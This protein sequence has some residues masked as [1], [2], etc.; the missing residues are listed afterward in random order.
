MTSSFAWPHSGHVR[1]DSRTTC[2]I[3]CIN[4]LSWARTWA[5]IGGYDLKD[6]GAVSLALGMAFL[7]NR[8]HPA[9]LGIGKREEIIRIC[10]QTAFADGK[11]RSQYGS[12]YNRLHAA[13]FNH[14]VI[15]RCPDICLNKCASQQH[16]SSHAK[17]EG[18]VRDCF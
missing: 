12:I 4:I 2:A 6:S 16:C 9:G 17:T 7:L 14:K 13:D 11:E 3:G 5:R 8:F 18:D 10:C 15:H 1:T